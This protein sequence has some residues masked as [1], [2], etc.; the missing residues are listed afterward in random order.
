VKQ[1]DQISVD[2]VIVSY[3][4]S[5]Q[6]RSCVEPLTRI[7]GVH[8]TVVDN[9]SSDR[10]LS[11]VSDL[12]VYAIDTRR[13]GGF[14]YGCNIG[15][16]SGSSPYVLFLNP[17][18]QLDD[19][20]LRTLVHVAE[21]RPRVGIVAPRIVDENGAL[22]FSLRRFPRLRST[23]AQALFLYRVA[24]TAAWSDEIIRAREHYD[25]PGIQEWA[26]GACLL[27]KRE[28]LELLGGWDEGFF[29]YCEDI[30]LCRRASDLG[31]ELQY[32]PGA[33]CVH[34]GGGSA[35]RATTL[36]LLAASRTRYA[37]IHRSRIGA[38]TERLG[39]ALEAT[40]RFL[41]R[42]EGPGGRRGHLLALRETLLGS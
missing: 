21:S 42:R 16:R 8:V 9:A 20:A 35:P 4:S 13:N 19:T 40:T 7:D 29:L 10:S 23:Y 18:A 2:A 36:P 22:Q 30:D 34:D 27:V 15:W 12:P 6:L 17:D 25:V 14:A 1:V 32:E 38:A 41:A 26:S 24:P 39:I 11:T 28:L 5:R 37:R 3:N 31:Y 33:T